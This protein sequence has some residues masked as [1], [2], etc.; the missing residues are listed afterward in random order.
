MHAPEAI[1]APAVSLSPGDEIT[2][3]MA[4]DAAAA[5]WTVSATNLATG[6]DSTLHISHRHAGA[7]DYDYAMLVNENI[8]LSIS[9]SSG[10]SDGASMTRAHSH[11]SRIRNKV[12]SIGEPWLDPGHV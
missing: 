6:E 12:G 3:F 5:E 7:T 8:I 2:S 9:A 1:T 10:R 4:Y 11:A